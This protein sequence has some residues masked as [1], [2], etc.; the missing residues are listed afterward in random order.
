VKLDLVTAVR[1]RGVS[2]D[3]MPDVLLLVTII[4]ALLHVM[5]GLTGI[6]VGAISC[7]QSHVLRAHSVS[8]IWSGICVSITTH[9][10]LHLLLLLLSGTNSLYLFVSLSLVP[11]P[12]FPTHLFLV[13]SP[14]T[15]SSFDSPL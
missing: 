10:V 8:P 2:R 7:A 13:P 11:V 15:S 3:T 12:P 5:S 1:S 4:F 6:C 14:I 9:S